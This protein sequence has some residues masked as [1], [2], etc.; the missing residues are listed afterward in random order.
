MWSKTMIGYGPEDDNF[1]LELTYNYGV[2]SYQLGN[3]YEAIT[4]HSKRVYANLVAQGLGT[5]LT[6]GS[7]APV[8]EVAAPDGYRFHVVDADPSTGPCPVTELALNVSDLERSLAFWSG[9][10]GFSV[11]R[12]VD[13]EAE[14]SCGPAQCLLRLRQLAPGQQL[15]RGTA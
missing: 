5:P 7:G 14:L 8:L 6:R 11:Q 9:F 1:V 15:E 13:G 10:L 12:S 4:I 2:K 3:D